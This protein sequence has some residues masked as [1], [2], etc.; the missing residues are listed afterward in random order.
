MFPFPFDGIHRNAQPFRDQVALISY[1]AT[2]GLMS[3]PSQQSRQHLCKAA[4]RS[5]AN[6]NPTMG[7][8]AEATKGARINAQGF[9]AKANAMPPRKQITA[10]RTNI[11]SMFSSSQ[12]MG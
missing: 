7:M 12:D 5:L 2:C 9:H 8:S 1:Q 6:I 4:Q 3:G 11:L 10:T